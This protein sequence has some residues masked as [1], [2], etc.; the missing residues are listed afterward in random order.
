MD[1][2][3]VYSPV[4]RS[5][6]AAQS[7]Q[8]TTKRITF[9][10]YYILDFYFHVGTVYVCV[11]GY[12]CVSECT[13]LLYVYR[14]FLHWSSAK[15]RIVPADF[16]TLP[17]NCLSWLIGQSFIYKLFWILWVWQVYF[18]EVWIVL[19][20]QYVMKLYS[21]DNFQLALYLSTLLPEISK[22]LP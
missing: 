2:F 1:E 19:T 7:C 11:R 17:R 14:H 12:E 8:I 5:G 3:Y 4:N 15:W 10:L 9:F 6:I 20:H 13:E 21:E 22:C 18:Q 16:C